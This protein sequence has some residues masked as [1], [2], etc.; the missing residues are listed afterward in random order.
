MDPTHPSTSMECRSTYCPQVAEENI[1][2]PR[3]NNTVLDV[4]QGIAP[5]PSDEENPAPD[6]NLAK[7]DDH[8]YAGARTVVK[9]N[10]SKE[11]T[12]ETDLEKGSPTSQQQNNNASSKFP[13]D[14]IDGT[15]SGETELAVTTS[16]GDDDDVNDTDDLS[17]GGSSDG[18][19]MEVISFDGAE[20]GLVSVPLAGE[21][22]HDVL[23]EDVSGIYRKEPNGCAICL[24]PFEVED[25]ITWS[26]NPSCQ[27]VF[28]DT[29]IADW[30]M[31]SGRKHLKKL[32]REQRRTGNLSYASDPVGKITGFPKL[33]PCCRQHFILEEEEDETVDEK[34]TRDIGDTENPGGA[35]LSNDE[36]MRIAA[37]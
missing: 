11:N 33:C 5:P 2:R 9:T 30:L 25:K 32:R 17:D 15:P 3:A 24:S 8:D 23:P 12:A 21:C 19:M 36:A 16:A 28:H 22:R 13:N 31:A 27:H 1:E 14:D 29:C 7:A 10:T 34:E 35:E 37:S 4:E 6:S 20:D 26:S 18:D